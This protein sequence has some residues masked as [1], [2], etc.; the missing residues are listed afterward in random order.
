MLK[1]CNHYT[2]VFGMT[3]CLSKTSYD[4]C[5]ANGMKVCNHMANVAAQWIDND[6]DGK[7]DDPNLEEYDSAQSGQTS[8]TPLLV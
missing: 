5:Q 1:A 2:Q 7:P 8:E 6:H 3:I 4:D